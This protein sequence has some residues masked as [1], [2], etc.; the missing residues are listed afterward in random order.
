MPTIWIIMI[1]ALIIG[2][3]A[4]PVLYISSR[5]QIRDL[6]KTYAA[7]GIMRTQSPLWDKSDFHDTLISSSALGI[8][9][10]IVPVAEHTEFVKIKKKMISRIKGG[11]VKNLSE[12]NIEKN[13][14]GINWVITMFS[15][16]SSEKL[17]AM[18]AYTGKAGNFVVVYC[19]K[20]PQ[21]D[22]EP[23]LPQLLSCFQQT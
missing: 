1:G 17:S 6:Q 3:I 18:L 23:M 7:L 12:N 20:I 11:W 13:Q 14:D 5:K 19:D 2:A 10:S 4:L 22:I 8:S 16:E 15:Y 9:L 21:A